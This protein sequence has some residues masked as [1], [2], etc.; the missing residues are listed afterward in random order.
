MP[1]DVAGFAVAASAG[2]TPARPSTPPR[3]DGRPTARQAFTRLAATLGVA[4]AVSSLWLF[5]LAPPDETLAFTVYIATLAVGYFVTRA[6]LRRFRAIFLDELQA[7]YTTKTFTQ[8]LF[9]IPRRGTGP[10]W[11]DDVVGWDW[12]GLW[13]LDTQG[14]VISAPD[15]SAD[16]PG[17]Y[18]SPNIPGSRELWT[19]YRW[20]GVFPE[21]DGEAGL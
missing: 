11:G 16:P 21:R 6:S 3:F 5:V 14:D 13:V 8:G 20:T 2:L 15:L 9:W 17:L 7:G 19:G 18:P 12:D 4:V 10:R 1:R